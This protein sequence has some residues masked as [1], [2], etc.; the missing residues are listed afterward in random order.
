M[1]GYPNPLGIQ[2][3]ET[4]MR[5]FA[6]IV[7]ANAFPNLP[8]RSPEAGA[9]QIRALAVVSPPGSWPVRCR[10]VGIYPANTLTPLY[11]SL[12][13]R[14]ERAIHFPDRRFWSTRMRQAVAR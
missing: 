14:P 1:R 6:V 5:L 2:S 3:A 8:W 9:E 12:T 11:E 7:L 4:G 13:I 10:L